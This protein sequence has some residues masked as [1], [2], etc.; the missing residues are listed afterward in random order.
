MSE[1][2]IV[3]K[4]KSIMLFINLSYFSIK[5]LFLEKIKKNFVFGNFKILQEKKKIFLRIFK[6]FRKKKIFFIN[7]LRSHTESWMRPK[8]SNLIK[9]HQRTPSVDILST[10]LTYNTIT[11]RKDDLFHFYFFFFQKNVRFSWNPPLFWLLLGMSE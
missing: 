8:C 4:V 5:K 1:I 10:Y 11:E 9:S 7:F 2:N 3:H 6:I